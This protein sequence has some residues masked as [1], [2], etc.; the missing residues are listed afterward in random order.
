MQGDS[1]LLTLSH[2]TESTQSIAAM[3]DSVQ[4]AKTLMTDAS[5]QHLHNVK[6][7]LR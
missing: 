6:H 5:T 2:L 3:L 1:D 4:V 7:S